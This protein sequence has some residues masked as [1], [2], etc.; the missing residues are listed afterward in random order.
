MPEEPN[1]IVD[2][3][4]LPPDSQL[5]LGLDGVQSARVDHYAVWPGEFSV[6]AG[7]REEEARLIAEHQSNCREESVSWS[8]LGRAVTNS[9]QLTDSS[10]QLDW[11]SAINRASSSRAPAGTENSPGHT[12]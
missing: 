11:C 6:P 3:M 2:W 7:A 5:L 1:G 12:A 4:K 9:L 8:E 10:R